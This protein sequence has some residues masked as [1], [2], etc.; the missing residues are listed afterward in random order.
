M[1]LD[2]LTGRTY[3]PARV[4]IQPGQVAAY[5]DATGDDPT[6][7]SA[8]APPSF[9]SA[10]LFAVAPL[11]LSDPIVSTEVR[12]VLHGEQ[13]FEWHRALDI[14]RPVEVTGSV[15]RVRIRSG[16]AFITFGMT[17]DD[18]AP[19]VE[20]VSL[21]VASG[22]QGFSG[23]D[24]GEPDVETRGP[25][26]TPSILDFPEP[27]ADV[28]PLRKSASRADLVKYAGASHDWNPIHWD[29]SSAVVAGLEGVIVHG[30]LSAAW[31]TQAAAR[32][33][34]SDHPLARARFRFRSPLRPAVP[35][36]V[37]GEVI[38]GVDARVRMALESDTDLHVAAEVTVTR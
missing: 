6:R 23:D 33:D 7:W 20:G 1:E 19:L 4:Q 26:D 27:G 8:A 21:F 22:E 32:Y 15:E 17:V 2:R 10:L 24:G 34:T 14:G 3:G 31:I 12:S 25:N 30:Q 29:H 38:D 35:T 9:A 36:R 37:T 5:V 11:F 16:A 13:T 18:G 28:A